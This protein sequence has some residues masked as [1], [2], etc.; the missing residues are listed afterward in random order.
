MKY[1]IKNKK[2]CFWQVF[3]YIGDFSFMRKVFHAIFSVI[4]KCFFKLSAKKYVMFKSDK[5]LL[6]KKH[7]GLTSVFGCEGDV[8][9]PIAFIDGSFLLRDRSRFGWLINFG[10]DRKRFESKIDWYNKDGWF[11]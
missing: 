3:L 1:R 2:A 7:Y 6:C 10:F 5:R 9:A 11:R 8:H 4:V